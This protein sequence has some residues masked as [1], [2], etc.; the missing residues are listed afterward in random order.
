MTTLE[1]FWSRNYLRIVRY[2]TNAYSYFSREDV[3]EVVSDV[4][5]LHF[6]DYKSRVKASGAHSEESRLRRWMIRRASFDMLSLIRAR[7]RERDA[8]G[9]AGPDD[10]GEDGEG[11]QE[12]AVFDDP[13]DWLCLQQR[14]PAVPEI[15]I[16]YEARGADGAPVDPRLTNKH[17]MAEKRF[18]AKLKG[19]SANDSIRSLRA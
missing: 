6:S 10:G 17:A 16:Q 4:I 5:R 7:S 12:E 8:S 2:V 15:L 3:E 13:S 9:L 11:A 19:R 1:E 14:L 18:L